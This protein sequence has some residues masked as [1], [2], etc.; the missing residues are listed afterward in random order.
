MSSATPALV[1]AKA[2]TRLQ[3]TYIDLLENKQNEA[4]EEAGLTLRSYVE[5]LAIMHT[6][7]TESD[8]ETEDDEENFEYATEF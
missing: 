3:Y 2:L 1:I 6:T 8:D 5:A 4:Y 7:A